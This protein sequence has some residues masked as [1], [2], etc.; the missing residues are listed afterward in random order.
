MCGIAGVFAPNLDPTQREQ[1][2][3][4][5]IRAQHHRGP[6]DQGLYSQGPIT[7]GMAR[8]AI[9]DPAN[10]RQPMH[11]ADGRFT[12]VFNGAIYNYRELQAELR[13]AGWPF[14]TNCDTEVLLAAYALRGAAC[15]PQLRGMF[16]FAVWDK[17]K[18]TLFAA[19]GPLGIKPLY[20]AR[21]PH[22]GLL[23]GSELNVLLA[24]GLVER[25]IDLSAV[26]EYLARFSIPAPRTLYQGLQNLPP[27]HCLEVL[28][29]GR[30]KTEAWWTMPLPAQPA[31]R[32][33]NYSDFVRGLR[34]QLE[35][36][37][38]AHQV[39]DV[40][41]GAF[42]SGGMDSSAIVGL[43]AR[44]GASQLKTF[45]LIFEEPGYSE[46]KSARMAAKTFGTEHHEFLLTG[47]QLAQDLPR[48]LAT[49]D[50][51]TGDGI[52]TFYASQMARAGG[53]KVALSGLGGDELFGSYPSFRDLPRLNSLLPWWR[54]LPQGLQ[55][56]IVVGLRSRTGA[57]ALKLA[58]FLASARDL[59]ELASLQRRVLPETVRLS[60]LS[61][62]ARAHAER[63]GPHHPLLDQFAGD[64]IGADAFQIISAWELRTY[65]A[66]VLLRDSDVFSM[67]HSLELRVP[68][69]DPVLLGWLWPQPAHFK[70]DPHFPKRALADAVTDVVPTAIR[71]RQKKGFA[72]P[73][74]LWMRRE[75]RPFLDET[76]SNSSLANC[77]WFD[78]AAVQ[79][80]WHEFLAGTDTRA[81]SRVWTIAVLIALVNRP[82]PPRS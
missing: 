1:A 82:S 17:E 29:N 6:D 67:A 20:Y 48:I 35:D 50:Q 36:T 59:H 28:P 39:A 37:I 53:V 45:S 23:F 19:R 31:V 8:L 51:P 41:V 47:A 70:R 21:L 73:F 10:G 64:L 66:D 69:V 60:L 5:M 22:G 12:I 13:A 30:L 7:I 15:L 58:D 79:T 68:F 57:R 81:W 33:L 25:E 74:G 44:T 16:A 9:I 40:P 63:L 80:N 76:F 27:G 55:K 3:T 38:R 71:H 43:M 2:V 56:R 78:T 54:K 34:A 75:L 18:Q 32:S 26:G 72:L 65:M 14:R 4:R 61:P 52:N 24:S 49:F 42:L 62:E 46:A 11:S 77:P